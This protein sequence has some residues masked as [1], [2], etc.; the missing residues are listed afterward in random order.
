MPAAMTKYNPEPTKILYL[1]GLVRSKVFASAVNIPVFPAPLCG[2][3]GDRG[4]K[5]QH[6]VASPRWSRSSRVCGRGGRRQPD[7]SYK[8]WGPVWKTKT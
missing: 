6:P 4:R 8:G 5:R 2:R 3:H 7:I 1:N